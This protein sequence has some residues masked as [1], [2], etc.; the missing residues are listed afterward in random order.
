MGKSSGKTMDLVKDWKRI[1]NKDTI[2]GLDFTVKN[3]IFRAAGPA[4]AGE[5]EKTN[6]S[7]DIHIEIV[8]GDTS[9][10]LLNESK[11]NQ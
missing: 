4:G 10:H 5:A 11:T 1:A 6:T 8:G 7:S 3:P 9:P 2:D